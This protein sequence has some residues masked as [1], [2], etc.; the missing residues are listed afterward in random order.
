MYR[1]NN[2]L[3]LA[4]EQHR[5]WRFAIH[6]SRLLVVLLRGEKMKGCLGKLGWGGTSVWGAAAV[7]NERAALLP[8]RSMAFS[9]AIVVFL[10]GY[11]GVA[12]LSSL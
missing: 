11:G 4:R 10:G 12:I 9:M 7:W 5:I 3:P 8:P 6:M 1:H 2:Q